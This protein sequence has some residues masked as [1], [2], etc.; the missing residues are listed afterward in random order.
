M[1]S[2]LRYQQNPTRVV[3]LLQLRNL[4]SHIIITQSLHEGPLLV[5]YT[6]KFLCGHVFSFLLGKYLEVELLVI[7]NKVTLCLP[8]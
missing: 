1:H 5:L 3:P 6:Y 2:L 4:H 8:I 7:G